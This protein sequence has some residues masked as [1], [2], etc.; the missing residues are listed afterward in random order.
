MVK[1]KKLKAVM[2][3][4]SLLLFAIGVTAPV[5]EA[6]AASVSED[7]YTVLTQADFD[8]ARANAGVQVPGCPVWCATGSYCSFFV[9]ANI[10]KLRIGSDINIGGDFDVVFS[11]STD[12]DLNGQ[13]IGKVY[14]SGYI[15]HGDLVFCG[16]G[17]ASA[18]HGNGA[19]NVR[20]DGGA[21][22]NI[23]SGYIG[24]LYVYNGKAV[25]NGGTLEYVFTDVSGDT[26]LGYVDIYG[27]THKELLVQ[28]WANS[29]QIYGG[30]FIPYE[31]DPDKFAIYMMGTTDVS[32]LNNVLP[33]G[34][35]FFGGECKSFVYP[36]SEGDSGQFVA[37]SGDVVT[38]APISSDSGYPSDYTGMGV[39][40]GEWRYLV[41]GQV[42]W[43]YTGMACNEAGWWYFRNGQLDWNYTGMALNEYGWW[44]YQNGQLNPFYTGMALNEY[45]WWYYTN[46]QLNPTYTGMA[47]NEY[48][49]WYYQNGMLDWTYTGMACNEYGWWYYNNGQI[50]WT[51]TGWA[52]NEYG[53]WW[54]QDG[55]LVL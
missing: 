33:N 10:N 28:S 15:G 53:N 29:V 8:L 20:V 38:V 9:D 25:V 52:T 19:A 12:V 11:N 24:D 22:V 55:R 50:D 34:Y 37:V 43:N 47:C 32:L 31:E 2:F 44:Y 30:T 49:W 4:V 23:E 14:G 42:N 18:V 5:K 21:F 48:G 7:G 26:P 51:Y 1:K 40:N 27:G 16:P 6:K 39:V 13:L 41:N 17:S 46:G 36:D 45:G 54:F 35:A 3:A